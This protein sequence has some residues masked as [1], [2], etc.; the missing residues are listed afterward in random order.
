MKNYLLIAVTALLLI[1]CASENK[2]SKSS[3]TVSI[4]PL[5]W[6]AS[7]LVGDQAMVEVL[8][9]AGSSPETYEPSAR[10]IEQLSGSALYLSTGLLDFEMELG[11]RMS[12]IA[13]NTELVNLSDSVEVIA[14]TCLHTEHHGHSHGVDPHIWLSPHAMKSIITQASA[15]I[16]KIGIA[17]TA[18]IEHRRDSLL[19]IVDSVDRYISSKAGTTVSFAIVH[20]SLSYFAKDYGL[21]QLSI[22]VDGK[23][24]ST[25]TIRSIVDQMRKEQ[26]TTI[27]YGVQTSDAV[28]QVVAKEVGCTLTPFDPLP[29]DWPTAMIKI[30]DQIYGTR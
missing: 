30:T 8:V 28:A 4:E 13:P 1:S 10:Q 23:E 24:P 12:S 26:I 11:E 27:F 15:A 16:I 5:W 6:V 14:G 29:S 20:P 3:I 9:P 21:R 17:Q 2:E 7:S 18:D 22:E 25:S 19:A